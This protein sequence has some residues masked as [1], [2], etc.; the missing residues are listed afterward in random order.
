MT[1][2]NLLLHQLPPSPQPVLP[3]LLPL[4]LYQAS[5][6]LLLLLSTSPMVDLSTL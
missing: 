4:L 3:Q 1:Q 5:L 2:L 6:L